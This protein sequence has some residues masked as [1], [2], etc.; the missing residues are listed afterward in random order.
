M[1]RS[2]RRT[3]PAPAPS[4]VTTPSSQAP[5]LAR[6]DSGRRRERP[7]DT[8]TES[9]ATVGS[10]AGAGGMA[11]RAPPGLSSGAAPATS[12]GGPPSPD[13]T[14]PTTTSTARAA[15][16]RDA[17][18]SS[19][20]S[21]LR[22]AWSWSAAAQWSGTA[23]VSSRSRSNW[24]K[25]LHRRATAG[26]LAVA[27]HAATYSNNRA[28]RFRNS[29]PTIRVAPHSAALR[30]RAKTPASWVATACITQNSTAATAEPRNTDRHDEWVCGSTRNMQMNSA[31]P[32]SRDAD[33]EM[34]RN[35]PAEI[36][37]S[38]RWARPNSSLPH[39]VNTVLA[40]S[41]TPTSTMR[42]NSRSALTATSTKKK[43]LSSVMS[44]S[45]RHMARMALFT[46]PIHPAP[47]HN[48]TTMAISPTV[49]Q[50]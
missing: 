31:Q 47:A 18:A 16:R 38:P 11:V 35:S 21:A 50:W 46:L 42:P 25:S 28:N 13:M 8:S 12:V 30:L 10:V 43:C 20:S 44:N 5:Q 33:N 2:P 26:W 17:V 29:N 37:N 3:R 39:P 41:S 27:I 19:V 6:V 24:S 48:A 15:A 4:P 45:G 32:P 14:L 1:R 34:S 22:S 49:C 7:A 40:A 23:I 9:L 36:L